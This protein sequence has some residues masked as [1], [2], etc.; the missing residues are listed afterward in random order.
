MAHN[1]GVR[2]GLLA[3]ALAVLSAA[4]AQTHVE[5]ILDASGSMYNRLG[6]GRYR[7]EAAKQVLVDLV[8]GLPAD[9]E[10]HVGLRVYGAR[11][12]ALD[13][14]AC[15]DSHLDVPIDGLDRAGLTDAIEGTVARGA[16][17][18]AYS[19]ALAAQDL[20]STGV[21]RVVLVTDGL[22]S[23]GGDLSAVAAQYEALGIDLR[24]VGFDLDQTA[25]EAFA[26]IAD[27]TNALD[28]TEL[29]GAL[30]E[31]L[32]DVTSAAPETVLVQVRVMRQGEV[33][34]QGV[35][36]MFLSSVDA[37]RVVLQPGEDGTFTAE[38]TPG[39]YDAEVVDAFTDG[40][41]TVTSGLSVDPDGGASFSFELAPEFE[42]ELSVTQPAPHAGARVS[43]AYSGASVETLGIVAISPT[44]SSDSIRLYQANVT[45]ASGSVD[46]LT[47]DTPGTFEAR[48]YL[49]LPEGGYRV[50][51]RSA[52]FQTVAASATLA[53]PDQVAAGTRFDVDWTGPAGLGD[54][55]V[56]VPSGDANAISASARPF[57]NPVV[58]QAPAQPGNYAL[59]YLTGQSGNVLATLAIEVVAAQVSIS[60]PSEVAANTTFEI[61][62]EGAVG[63]QDSIVLVLA[64][65]PDAGAEVFGPPRRIYSP[66]VASRAPAEPGAYELRYLNAVGEVLARFALTVR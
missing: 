7:I 21:R 51:G 3:V 28:A 30:H 12:Q 24:I 65:A 38:M 1:Q 13:E 4:F 41:T 27:F 29:S 56:V 39:S 58:V 10:L 53:A 36:V 15:Q 5:L 23:C 63:P 2:T 6:D 50:L 64:G 60:A 48:Y 20:P 59:R 37:R 33:T 9:P 16:T 49:K 66:R 52:A 11:L 22:E 14:G 40:R 17:P 43:V 18:I 34:T 62:V 47:P 46:L 26:A 61:V 42:V 19:L 55:I 8:A 44:E 35:S 57:T 54:A 45:T 25:A 32:G 31:A